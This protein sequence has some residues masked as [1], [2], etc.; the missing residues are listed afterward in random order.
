[1]L[2]NKLRQFFLRAATVNGDGLVVAPY[3]DDFIYQERAFTTN[4]I[5]SV[6]ETPNLLVLF[7]PTLTNYA[8]ALPLFFASEDGPFYVTLYAGTNYTGGTAAKTFN[9]YNGSTNAHDALITFSS[10]G[11]VSGVS[12][13]TQVAKYM[14][15]SA[16]TNQTAG[17]GQASKN[18]PFVID[19]TK[20]YL[21]EIENGSSTDPSNFEIGFTW[22]E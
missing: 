4:D 2:S 19:T 21:L 9:R 13:G 18:L 14:V 20:K 6:P 16:S 11:G 12:K 15:G 8:V 3:A 7:D 22:Y 5:Y 1:M 10:T 17:G